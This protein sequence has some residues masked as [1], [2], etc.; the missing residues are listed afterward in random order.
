MLPRGAQA[1]A[2]P[3]ARLATH[4]GGARCAEMRGVA[5]PLP[6][7]D[8]WR[9]PSPQ[10]CI[11]AHLEREQAVRAG[12]AGSRPSAVGCEMLGVGGRRRLLLPVGER[13]AAAEIADESEEP[14]P[15]PTT[16]S[17]IAAPTLEHG[18][19]C[20]R[21][22]ITQCDEALR[23]AG[24]LAHGALVARAAQGTLSQADEYALQVHTVRR[25]A[26][27][28]LAWCALVL[29]D[30]LAAL[31]WCEALLAC[32]GLAHNLKAHA[33]TF[34]CDALCHLDRSAE[35]AARARREGGCWVRR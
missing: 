21:A 9:R 22:A 11:A 1:A 24:G 33:H 19:K 27:L 6:H 25:V 31:G 2:P 14:P 13:L 26:T 3:A 35:V 32:E 17:A 23:T 10:A 8:V 12:R 18:V 7:T 29:A 28:Q 4:G 20:L 30:P 15:Q 16:E 34:A 5:R